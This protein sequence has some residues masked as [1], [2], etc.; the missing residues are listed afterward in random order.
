MF[1]MAKNTDR[2][3]IFLTTNEVRG[4]QVFLLGEGRGVGFLLFP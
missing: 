2:Q 1:K 4:P 3:K